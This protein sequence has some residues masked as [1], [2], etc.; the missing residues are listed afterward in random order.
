MKEL[1]DD[2][3]VVKSMISLRYERERS[4]VPTYPTSRAGF[5]SSLLTPP[6]AQ[7]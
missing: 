5:G 2:R 1:A 7:G 6:L 4:E 3:C